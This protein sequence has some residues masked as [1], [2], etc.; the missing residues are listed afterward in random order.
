MHL[1]VLMACQ[2]RLIPHLLKSKIK[3]LGHFA[4][5]Q[6]EKKGMRERNG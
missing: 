5:L 1:A 6:E 2:W 4:C 3:E